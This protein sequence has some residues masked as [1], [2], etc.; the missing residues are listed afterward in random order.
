MQATLRVKRFD[1]ESQ[2]GSGFQDFNIEVEDWYTVLDALIKVREEIDGTLSLRCSCRASICGS[3]GMRVNGMA[4]LVCKT[5]LETVSPNGEPIVIEPMGNMPVMKDLVT[6][7]KPFWDKMKQVTPYL[8][9]EGEA[10]EGEYLASNE[11]MVHLVGVMNCI[12]CGACVSDCTAL[13]VDKNFIAPAALAKAYRFVEDPRDGHRQERL[14]EL[15]E[16]G[17]IWDCTRC[18][19]CVEVCPKDVAPMDR[20]MKMRESAMQSGYTNTS[21][22]RHTKSFANS[23]YKHGRLDETR[24]AIESMGYTNLPALLGAAPV[25]I[26]AMMRGKFPWRPH[27]AANRENIKRV[28]E[29]VGGNH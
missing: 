3:C 26:R 19:Y 24:L 22:S 25:G 5:R 8:Q 27:K 4:R 21:G 17:G 6:D 15:N 20:I 9:P 23:V 10:P 29:K 2:E 12:M 1:P 7:F 14:G 18:M 16:Y 13:E 28:F 11:S